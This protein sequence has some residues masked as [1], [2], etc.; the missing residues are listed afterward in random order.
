[1]KQLAD[2]LTEEL[3]ANGDR[4]AS[5]GE[6]N[7]K[8]LARSSFDDS[9]MRNVLGLT[10]HDIKSTIIDMANSVISLNIQ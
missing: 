3:G 7:T 6:E 4:I 5:E 2:I 1:M 9:R 10:P 8:P